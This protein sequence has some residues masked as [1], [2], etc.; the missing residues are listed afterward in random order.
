[1]IGNE[2]ESDILEEDVF[3]ECNGIDENDRKI[4]GQ[5]LTQCNKVL[6]KT[7]SIWKEAMT[8]VVDRFVD[9]MV[10]EEVYRPEKISIE[11]MKHIIKDHL[12]KNLLTNRHLDFYPIHFYSSSQYVC[13]YNKPYRQDPSVFH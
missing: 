9:K 7:K 10:D 4:A 13:L 3:T 2:N 8:V 6:S 5:L 11:E 12:H 1:M